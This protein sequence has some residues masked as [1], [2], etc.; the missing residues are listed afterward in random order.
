MGLAVLAEIAAVGVDNRGGVVIHTGHLFLVNGH[1]DDH[2][3]LLRIFLHEAGRMTLGNALRSGIP[4]PVLARAEIGL[5][6]H[7]LKTQDLNTLFSGIFDIG[8]MGVDHH[9]PNLLGIL[10]HIALECHLDQTAL[11]FCHRGPRS[12]NHILN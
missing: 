8:D 12:M 9:V 10:R 1:D 6:K 7:F 3:V 5:C 4:L 2:L 11:Q